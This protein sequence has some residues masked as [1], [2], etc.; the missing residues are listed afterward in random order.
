VHETAEQ[1]RA[2]G[3]A[4]VDALAGNMSA[5]DLRRRLLHLSPQGITEGSFFVA[6][7]YLDLPILS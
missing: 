7:N 3:E 2:I 4:F 5:A 1:T 6:E